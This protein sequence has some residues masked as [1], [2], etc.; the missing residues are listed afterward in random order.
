MSANKSATLPSSII[1][2]ADPPSKT[3]DL[4]RS[5]TPVSTLGRPL[6][7]TFYHPTQTQSPATQ[8]NRRF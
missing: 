1:K 2:I 3:K 7:Y 6:T 4:T 8:P 5:G